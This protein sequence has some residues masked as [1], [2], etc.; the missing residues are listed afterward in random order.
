M[1]TYIRNTHSP[2]MISIELEKMR[3][4]LSQLI[5]MPDVL[6]VSKDYAEY[7]GYHSAPEACEKFRNK[8]REK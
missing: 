4:E 3:P 2:P 6:F 1:V 8:T 7:H 5:S